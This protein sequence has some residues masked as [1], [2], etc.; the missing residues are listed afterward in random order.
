MLGG[1]SGLSPQLCLGE[2]MGRAQ[3]WGDTA[4]H[5]AGSSSPHPSDSSS[6]E[7]PMDRSSLPKQLL[8]PSSTKQ[9]LQPSRACPKP[10]HHLGGYWSPHSSPKPPLS[11]CRPPP[12]LAAPKEQRASSPLPIPGLLTVFPGVGGGDYIPAAPN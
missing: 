10:Q 7:H 12:H 6:P 2:A 3:L 1:S 4:E 5:Q 11:P 9:M 8:G